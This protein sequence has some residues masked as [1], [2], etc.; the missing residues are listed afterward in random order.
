MLQA[1]SEFVIFNGNIIK[2]HL[3]EMMTRR[4]ITFLEIII[5]YIA[6]LLELE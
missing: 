1:F 3:G 5:N 2:N 4:A 6:L